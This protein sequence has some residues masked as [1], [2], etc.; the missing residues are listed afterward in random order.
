MKKV[1]I[2]PRYRCKLATFREGEWLTQ[3][4]LAKILGVSRQ[5]IIS[6]ERTQ[7]RPSLEL[8]VKMARFFEKTVEEVFLFP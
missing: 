8:A 1:N 3:K 6:I 7:K 4:Q 5:T 2:T